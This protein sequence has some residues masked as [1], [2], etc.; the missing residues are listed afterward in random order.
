MKPSSSAPAGDP[1]IGGDIAADGEC[2]ALVRGASGERVTAA[3]TPIKSPRRNF[4][5]W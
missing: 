1:V 3:A 2:R 4:V 5:S